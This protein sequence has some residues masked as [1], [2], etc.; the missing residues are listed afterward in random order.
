MFFSAEDGETSM[1]FDHIYHGNLKKSDVLLVFVAGVLCLQLGV[2]Y[3][4]NSEF[5]FGVIP[6]TWVPYMSLDVSQNGIW[7]AEKIIKWLDIDEGFGI[8]CTIR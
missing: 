8:F 4:G 6:K 1:K 2:S 5:F 7:L 3:M